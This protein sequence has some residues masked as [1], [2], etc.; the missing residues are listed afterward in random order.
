MVGL[1]GLVWAVLLL[2]GLG[3]MQPDV[4]IVTEYELDVAW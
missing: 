4:A 1:T 2:V 3:K